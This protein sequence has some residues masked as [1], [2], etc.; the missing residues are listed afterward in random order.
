MRFCLAMA[1]QDEAHWLKLHLP[2]I[3]EAT[4]IDG[5]V[6]LDGGS[7]D[8]GPEIL[9]ELGAIVY[10]RPF[11]WDFAAHMNALIECC[12]AEGYD[13]ML[14]LDPDELMWPADV[15][16]VA[17]ALKRHIAVKLPTYHFEDDRHQWMP[18]HY[19]DFHIRAWRLDEDA[20]RYKGKVHEWPKRGG[21]RLMAYEINAHLY[22]Y[23]GIRPHSE[24]RRLKH[25]NYQRLKA[26]K[27]ALPELPAGV[28]VNGKYR[29][30]EPFAELQPLA[31]E[32]I[33]ARAP[34][35]E[36]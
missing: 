17:A 16:A 4:S 8:D 32:E 21:E 15:D 31:P 20:V 24:R 1:F 19:P 26:G 7:Q 9:V 35:E 23:E 14:R 28:R 29:P 36:A 2:R 10:W 12:E 30:R 5:V 13:A 6:A 3:L 34:F 25:L 22:H 27:D 18:Q 33:G 11:D